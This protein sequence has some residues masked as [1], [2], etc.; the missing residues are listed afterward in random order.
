MQPDLPAMPD[1]FVGKI[2]GRSQRQGLTL[3]NVRSGF[4]GLEHLVHGI[5][6]I[7]RRGPG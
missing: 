5:H 7:H 4:H 1:I 3:G 6:R 2:L